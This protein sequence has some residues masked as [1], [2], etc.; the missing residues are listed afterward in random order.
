MDSLH[1]LRNTGGFRDMNFSGLGRSHFPMVALQFTMKW[2]SDLSTFCA[3]S[4][5]LNRDDQ[6]L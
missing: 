3:R 6:S 5:H 4:E 2:M 1:S